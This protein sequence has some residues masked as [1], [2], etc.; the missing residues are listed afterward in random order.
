MK[1]SLVMDGL[2]TA[3]ALALFVAGCTSGTDPVPPLPGSGNFDESCPEGDSGVAPGNVLKGYVFEGYVDPSQGIGEARRKEINMC[4]FYDPTGE[5]LWG[6][7]SP[8]EEASPKPRAVI[9]TLAAGWCGPCREEAAKTLPEK[10]ASYGPQGLQ[11]VTVLADT[12]TAGESAGWKELET[13]VSIYDVQYVATI[14]TDRELAN[15]FPGTGGFPTNILVDARTLG[16]VESLSG[17]PD[18]GFYQKL[19]Q[20]LAE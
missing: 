4:S 13:W 20:L 5:G 6:A 16:I 14:D 19:E 3:M 15:E 7:G 9:I 17:A 8:F 1:H 10:Y 11:I 2:R 18:A 12:T